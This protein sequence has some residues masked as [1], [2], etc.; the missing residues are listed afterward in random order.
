MFLSTQ[1][2]YLNMFEPHFQGDTIFFSLH[3]FIT[4][5]ICLI[6]SSE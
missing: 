3:F 5:W 6:V 1:H 4:N 2:L